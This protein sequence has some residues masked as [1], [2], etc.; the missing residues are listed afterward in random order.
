MKKYIS[1]QD[2]LK[3]ISEFEGFA[4]FIFLLVFSIMIGSCDKNTG[5]P[6]NPVAKI[7][8][9]FD[10]RIDGQKIVFDE[11]IYANSAGNPYL[12]NEIQTS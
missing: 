7:N 2:T 8:F 6:E 5:Q 11:M 3:V 12:V 9:N 4:S 10:H 1:I